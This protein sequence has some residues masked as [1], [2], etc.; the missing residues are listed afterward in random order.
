MS[1]SYCAAGV[2]SPP[3]LEGMTGGKRISLEEYA[4]QLFK[5]AT[6]WLGWP[7]DVAMK[8][9]IPQIL[10]ALDGKIDF[11]KKTNPWGSEEKKKEP[12]RRFRIRS[13]QAKCTCF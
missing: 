13:L 3:N 2:L 6:G 1:C 12:A 11:L 10:L 8:T 5:Y 7:P 9:S 4:E